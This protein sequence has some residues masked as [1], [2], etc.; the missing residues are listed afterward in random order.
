MHIR[1][2]RSRA[3]VGCLAVV[4]L[5]ACS[6][7]HPRS[8]GSPPS[9]AAPSVAASSLSSVASPTINCPEQLRATFAQVA[10][11]NPVTVHA[12]VASGFTKC[13]YRTGVASPV[14]CTAASVTINTAPQAFK[15]FNRWAVETTQNA[16]AGPGPGLAPEQINGIGVLADWVPAT[17]LF[18]TATE[19]RWIA[20]QLTCA[21]GERKALLLAE[22]LARA[23]LNA[24]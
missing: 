6:A 1:A 18:E 8:S 16:G 22:A 15:N 17:Q 21:P 5:C 13:D 24:S 2:C 20:V 23:G 3:I 19:T 7:S 4:L 14:A 10:S 12:D 9:T 11:R